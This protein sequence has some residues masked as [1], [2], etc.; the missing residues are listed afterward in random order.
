MTLGFQ[1]F[2]TGKTWPLGA[3]GPGNGFDGPVNLSAV[4]PLPQA[5]GNMNRPPRLSLTYQS[6]RSTIRQEQIQLTHLHKHRRKLF[7][8]DS[9]CTNGPKNAACKAIKPGWPI[10]PIA[11]SLS[12][13]GRQ[14]P[15]HSFASFFSRP[16]LC[17]KPGVSFS[18]IGRRFFG[19]CNPTFEPFATD[20][21]QPVDPDNLRIANI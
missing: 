19:P 21:D 7:V 20:S 4:Y 10:V 6:L 16:K 3:F 14:F 8:R 5:G 18:R 13:A 17:P 11:K 15:I 2:G 1:N 12:L 9:V